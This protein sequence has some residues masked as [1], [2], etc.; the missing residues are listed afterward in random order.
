MAI[1]A[2]DPAEW[3]EANIVQLDSDAASNDVAIEEIEAWAA[4]N[5]FARINETWLRQILRGGR[6][7]FRGVCYR[8]TDEERQSR[9]ALMERHDAARESLPRTLH[10]RRA[11]E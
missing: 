1:V 4:E 8:L 3:R 10:R 6:R 11:A 5:G 9:T 2:Y 7:V